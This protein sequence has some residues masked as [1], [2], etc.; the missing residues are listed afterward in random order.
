MAEPI[1]KRLKHA[2][3]AFTAQDKVF[4][5]FEPSGYSYGYRPDRV[6]L[7]LANERSIISSIYTRLGI[8]V[9]AVKVQHVRMDQNGRF[10]EEI[11]SGLNEC[12]TVRANLDQT[13]R[14]FFQDAAMTLFDEGTIAIVPVETTLD[15]T[16]TGSYDIKKLRVGRIVTWYPQHVKIRLYD[17]S[18]GMKKD[19]V[20][21]KNVVAIVE[22]PLYSV[23]NEPNSTLKRYVR[24][25]NLL[26]AVD[27]RTS[28]GKLD[29]II[30][31]P[32][33]I[34]SDARRAQAEQRRK[35]I[36]VQLQGSAYGIAYTDGTEKITQLNRPAENT[37]LEQIKDLKVSLFSELGLT[38]EIFNGTADEKTMINYYY[39]TIEPII[40]A[41]IDSMRSTFLT[42]SARTQLQDIMFFRDP[43]K[44]VPV[45]ELA[46]AGDKFTRNA[47]LSSNEFRA[48]LG[49]RPVQTPEAEE[50][51]NKNLNPSGPPAED[52]ST[53]PPE[54]VPVAPR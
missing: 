49:Y 47:I 53:A 45:L 2:W 34:K 21:A 25:L 33:V 38:E 16:V 26:D 12:L 11:K 43:F 5:P 42:K 13:A 19:V 51:R 4:K 32:Y 7:N 31:L 24:K 35:D 22:N 44:L 54:G 9:A 39:R 10:L 15:P 30:Q 28:S 40:S 6:R 8:D 17:E 36:E 20:L 50:L 23:M 3:D 48:V 27:E 41:I 52:S 1:G 14:A 37:L 29:L 46:D 18:D